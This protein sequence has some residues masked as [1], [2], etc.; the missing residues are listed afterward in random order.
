MVSAVTEAAVRT[1]RTSVAAMGRR[2]SYPSGTF[3]WTDLGTTDSAA[4]TAFYAGLFGWRAEVLPDQGTGAYTLLRADDALVAALYDMTQSPH[5]AW[6]SY[7]SVTD[8]DA[9]AAR[10][11][12]VGGRLLR[13]ASDVGTSGRM[14]LVADPTN[15]VFAL[16]QAADHFGAELVNDPGALCLN[17]CNTSDPE[18]AQRFYTELFGWR[19]EPT[20]TEEQAYWGLYNGETLNAGMMPLPPGSPAPSHWLVYFTVE[21]LD[22]AAS[23]IAELTGSVIVPPTVIP[24]GGRFLVASDPQGAV[25]ALFEGQ[26]DP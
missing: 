18:A 21:S 22:A 11:A 16:W 1:G 19:V 26:V 4:A 20:G 7:V 12:D 14:A 10:V 5:P 2:T 8:V 9:T 13:P 25:F 15:A 24:G 3:C 23:T 17:Q 6:L